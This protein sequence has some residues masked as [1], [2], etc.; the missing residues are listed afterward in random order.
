MGKIALLAPWL[1]RLFP[2]AELPGSQPLEVSGDISYTHNI[3]S[4]QDDLGPAEE[5]GVVGAAGGLI[6][7]LI[8]ALED[9]SVL[10]HAAQVT[11]DDPASRQGHWVL[12]RGTTDVSVLDGLNISISNTQIFGLG[13]TFLVPPTWGLGFAFAGL[14][15][16]ARITGLIIFTRVPIGHPHQQ[17]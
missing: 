4:G 7:T 17:I 16:G 10:V 5:V 3:F 15:A 14:D 11:H 1:Q 13:R 12:R 9:E 8:D 2:P 6:I